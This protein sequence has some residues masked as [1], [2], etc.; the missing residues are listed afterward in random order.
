MHEG[1]MDQIKNKMILVLNTGRG[2]NES[3]RMWINLMDDYTTISKK[4][5]NHILLMVKHRPNKYKVEIKREDENTKVIIIT[6][7]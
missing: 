2:L 6:W 7:N 5:Y 1:Q 3:R 4:E